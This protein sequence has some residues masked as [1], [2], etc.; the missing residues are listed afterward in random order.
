MFARCRLL[1]RAERAVWT[2][3]SVLDL[4]QL[5]GSSSEFSTSAVRDLDFGFSCSCILLSLFNFR[6]FPSAPCFAFAGLQSCGGHTEAPAQQSTSVGYFCIS[7]ARYHFVLRDHQGLTCSASP[8]YSCERCTF[9]RAILRRQSF[10]P[11]TNEQKRG[12][13]KTRASC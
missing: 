3:V 7:L 2:A 4:R 10:L 6:R 11:P 8:L 12:L 5:C 13:E 9:S 1:R